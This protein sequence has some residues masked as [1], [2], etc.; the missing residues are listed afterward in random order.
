[1][2]GIRTPKASTANNLLETFSYDTYKPFRASAS[3]WWPVAESNRLMFLSLRFAYPFSEP[4]PAVAASPQM[5]KHLILKMDYYGDA[6][7]CYKN[8]LRMLRFGRH[9][10]IG[11]GGGLMSVPCASAD[12]RQQ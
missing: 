12:A 10:G 8:W 2:P 11:P 5:N 1:M 7:P 6:S 9:P 3:R 4:I